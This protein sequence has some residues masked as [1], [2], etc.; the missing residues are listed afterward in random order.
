MFC[1]KN[2]FQSESVRHMNA[3]KGAAVF[4]RTS[5]F[6]EIRS[7]IPC[8]KMLIYLHLDIE[9]HRGLGRPFLEYPLTRIC[10]SEKKNS[11]Y[12]VRCKRM[13]YL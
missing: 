12:T 10:V 13:G 8:I 9:I 5:Q 1:R 6:G 11:K 7:R 4:L 2:S 3:W